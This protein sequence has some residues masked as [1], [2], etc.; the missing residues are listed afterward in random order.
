MPK[1]TITIGFVQINSSFAGQDYF[2]LSVGL[3]QA[4]LQKYGA[5]PEACRF[6]APVCRRAPLATIVKRLAG[7]EIVGFSVYVWNQNISLAIA[8]RLKQ[9]N[10][11]VLIVFG[12]P[13]VPNQAEKFLRQN[14]FVDL[15]CHGEG[16]QI[17]TRI[18]EKYRA[19]DWQAIPSISYLDP[20]G[21]LRA[22]PQAGRIR[23]L[24]LIPSPYLSGVFDPLL[25]GNRG[26]QWLGLWETNRGCPFQCAFCEWGARAFNRVYCFDLERLRAEIR[27]FARH[28]IEF[29]FCCDANFGLFPRDV[30]IAE[31]IAAAR[32]CYGFP[33]AFSVQSTKNAPE[34]IFNIQKLLNDR[35]LNKGVLLALQSATPAV[36]KNIR[37]QNI[38]LAAFDEL[39]KRFQ[40]EGIL[41]FTDLIIGL[42]GETYA[43]FAEGVAQI[44]AKGQ[45]N[46]IQFIN[47]SILGNAVMGDPAYQRRYG[48]EIVKSRIINIHGEAADLADDVVETQELVVATRAMPKPDWIKAR[49][50]AWMT[51]LI[52]FDKLL[53]IPAALLHRYGGIGY[54][55]LLECF[56]AAA[57]GKYPLFAGIRAFFDE[58]A[59]SIQA[60]G[61]EYCRAPQWLDIWW[62]ADEYILI[63]L[64]AEKKLDQFYAEAEEI[65]SDLAAAAGA[66]A[67]FL[68]EALGLNRAALKQ[69]GRKR[70][71]I[72]KLRYNVWELYRAAL[73]GRAAPLQEGEY[74]HKIVRAGD[75][76][77]TFPDWCR[78]V[79][80]YQNK[81]GAYLNPVIP[82]S[83]KPGSRR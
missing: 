79:V 76:G 83:A 1:Q 33:R 44:I 61:P 12:G 11:A 51:S 25:A 38:P 72:L 18:V 62:P 82:L 41:T 7:A 55:R 8:Q 66:P 15:V 30:R 6:L 65:F 19:R 58:L 56:L 48:L 57:P 70:D 46:R 74:K 78:Q 16:E 49:V 69:P 35:R 45:H 9:L 54:R 63:K 34:R 50:F 32:R 3:L 4:Y 81:K 67:P 2:P 20:A 77:K 73:E 59:R 10:P 40:R 24:A 43:S 47:L 71:K 5:A 28:K 60:G 68:K 14:P 13:Q 36:L 37:R 52:Y 75:Q 64:C 27:W 21:A 31:M 80:W 42:P 26:R 29:I 17:F 23:D 39:Q 22:H 53:Q